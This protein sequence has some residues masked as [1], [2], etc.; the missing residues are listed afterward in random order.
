V[1]TDT[2]G[3][4]GGSPKPKSTVTHGKGFGKNANNRFIVHDKSAGNKDNYRPACLEFPS[5]KVKIPAGAGGFLIVYT[6]SDGSSGVLVSW[7]AS[8]DANGNAGDITFGQGWVKSGNDITLA[9]KVVSM[10]WSID[11]E[12][13]TQVDV[14]GALALVTIHYCPGGTCTD[15]SGN[16]L[17]A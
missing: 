14:N 11:G 17:C 2:T 5:G 13:S 16:D 15:D 10:D 8:G 6:A 12:S 1:V 3:I 7:S 9:V 4:L